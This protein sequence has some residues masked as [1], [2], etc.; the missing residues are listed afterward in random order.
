MTRLDHLP[1]VSE[2]LLED[3]TLLS[4]VD[5]K[6]ILRT[7]ELHGLIENLSPKDYGIA[8]HIN[9]GMLAYEN[10]YFDTPGRALL[11]AHHRGQRPRYKVRFRHHLS[12]E[13]SYFE[14]KQKKSSGVTAKTRIPVE[15]RM[16]TLG[17]EEQ[18]LV[19]R[20]RRMDT[21]DLQPAMRIGFERGMLVGL[22]RPER[23]SLDTGLWFGD[24]HSKVELNELVIVEVKQAR[25]AARSPI[26][27]AL[28]EHGAL[29]LRVSKYV[30]GAQLL[31]PDI[32]LNR[33]RNRLRMLRRRIAS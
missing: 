20:Q 32:R 28:R 27:R 9:G 2:S 3:R 30:T 23:I 8:S 22:D 13:L 16:D 11:R 5:T 12:R 7:T 6:F 14:L 15:F 4:R 25:F 33:Y 1:L 29:Q 17:K 26:M 18:A 24:G 10:L 21:K 19:H 31:W